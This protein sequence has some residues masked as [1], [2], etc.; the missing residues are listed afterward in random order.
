MLTT[1]LAKDNMKTTDKYFLCIIIKTVQ[2]KIS[3]K[4]IK[5]FIKRVMQLEQEKF[6]QEK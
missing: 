6:I 2:N 1:K 4:R 5:Q 3:G